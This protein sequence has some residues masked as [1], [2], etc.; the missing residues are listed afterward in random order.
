MKKIT[1]ILFSVIFATGILSGCGSSANNASTS[2]SGT[3]SD[4]LSSSYADMMKS[5]KY[6]M[7]YKTKITVGSQTIYA[8][9]TMATDGK[10]TSIN[11]VTGE[12]KTHIIMRDSKVYMINDADKSYL[13]MDVPAT[14]NVQSDTGTN[15]I[16][17]NGLAYIGKG[18]ANL[19]G[20]ELDY[21]EYKTDS[22]TMRYYFDGSKLYGIGVKAGETEVIM[23][24][25][26]MS[27]KITEDMFVIPTGY[28]EKSI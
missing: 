1:S 21:E 20:K 23:E 22:G 19:N 2:T 7:H 5:G 10:S 18:K 9:T 27:N 15:K 28:T 26:E 16:D 25:I 11:G 8:D 17:T 3:K 13:K 24:I 14:G 6:F 12:V 4:L